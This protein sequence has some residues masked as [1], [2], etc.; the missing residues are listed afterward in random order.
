M[1]FAEPGLAPARMLAESF[2]ASSAR[3]RRISFCMRSARSVT[4]FEN[5]FGSVDCSVIDVTRRMVVRRCRRMSCHLYPQQLPPAMAQNQERKQAI[6]GQGRDHTDQWRR[7][8]ARGFREMSSSFATAAFRPAP[9]IWRPS[10]GPPQS[11]ASAVR[12][13]SGPRPTAMPPKDRLRLHHLSH[14][15]QTRPE[16][17]GSADLNAMLS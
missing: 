15:E 3:A 6:K 8:P 12:H 1:P 7:S 9:C 4:T 10:T 17:G 2:S 13:G 16:P 11:P 5:A 14:A